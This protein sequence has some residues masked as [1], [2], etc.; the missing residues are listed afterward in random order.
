M[1]A[2]VASV[3]GDT[4]FMPK[5]PTTVCLKLKWPS[6][7]ETKGLVI[8]DIEFPVKTKALE[9]AL[10]VPVGVIYLLSLQ[11]TRHCIHKPSLGPRS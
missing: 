2:A 4:L 8:I 11:N 9:K 1:S 6:N 10:S 7:V 3:S 5:G